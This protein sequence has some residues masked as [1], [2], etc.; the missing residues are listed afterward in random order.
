MP[1][2]LKLFPAKYFKFSTKYPVSGTQLQLGRSYQFTSPPQAPD[3]R[4]INLKLLGMCY[5]SGWNGI[6]LNEQPGRNMGVL[7][8]FY[9]EHKLAFKFIFNHP[10]YGRLICRF[11]KPLEIP[12]GISNGFGNLP[13]FEVELIEIP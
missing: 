2:P 12:E 4:V 13:D 9:N 3:Q 7:E 11:N 5:F 6:D 8:E 10:V 1:D